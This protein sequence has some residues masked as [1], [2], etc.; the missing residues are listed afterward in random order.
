MQR[1]YGDGNAVHLHRLQLF[2]FDLVMFRW[3]HPAR[4]HSLRSCPQ[5]R[6]AAIEQKNNTH[7]HGN[8][9]RAAGR[10]VKHGRGRG[11][12]LESN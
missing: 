2:N 8:D 12:Q 5:R 6:D 4:K 3:Q 10:K 11:D 9:A 7:P 1:N